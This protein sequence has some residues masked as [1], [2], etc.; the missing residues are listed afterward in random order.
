MF[1]NGSDK[2]GVT[3]ENLSLIVVGRGRFHGHG[4]QPGF[5]SRRLTQVRFSTKENSSLIV[6]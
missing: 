3:E 5:N 4:P 6:R 2:R 1:L